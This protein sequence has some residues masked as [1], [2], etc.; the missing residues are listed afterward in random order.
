MKKVLFECVGN[1]VLFALFGF[2]MMFPFAVHE[3]RVDSDG[4][5]FSVSL[6]SSM[7]VLLAFVALFM[8]VRF[9]FAKRNGLAIRMVDNMELA[10]E[11]ERERSILAK[12]L[13]AAYHAAMVSLIVCFGVLALSYFFAVVLYGASAEFMYRVAIGCVMA[14]LEIVNAA[15][16][17]SWCVEYRK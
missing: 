12:A 3:S 2:A 15:Y 16:C 9:V 17:I 4:F 6:S 8:V 5:A 13:F 1:G 14:T 11:D 10:C 7:I